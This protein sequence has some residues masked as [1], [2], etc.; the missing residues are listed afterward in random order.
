MHVSEI[1]QSKTPAISFEIFPPK[2]ELPLEE[3]RNIVDK[4]ATCSPD[5]ISVT[6]SAGGSGNSENTIPI[7]AMIQDE[8]NIPAI[9]HQTCFGYTKKEIDNLLEDAKKRGV[10]NFLALRGD[11]TP[12]LRIHDYAYAKDLIPQIC[13]YGFCAGGAAYPEGHIDCFDFKISIKHLKEKQ[14][15]GASYFITQLVYDNSLYYRFIEAARNEGITVPITVGVMP[16]NSK[17]GLSTM[18]FLTGATIPS[19][20]IKTIAKYTHDQKSLEAAGVEYACRQ[21]ED[22][23]THGVDGVH[24]YMMNKPP[25]AHAIRDFINSIQH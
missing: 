1:L 20:L 25:I 9:A 24:I 8:F 3:A 11:T 15:A 10:E 12:D 7:T 13:S 2:N 23:L 21:I 22:L 4:L 16:F 14:D 5:F 6:C 19:S 17:S 18:M